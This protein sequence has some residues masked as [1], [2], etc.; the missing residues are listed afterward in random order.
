[1]ASYI[2]SFYEND[3]KERN[4]VLTTHSKPVEYKGYLIYHRI[5]GTT[6]N[7]DVFDSVKDG[8]CVGMSAGLNGAK[9]RI[10]KLI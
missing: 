4:P 1:M 10:D 9:N 3:K 6:K 2:N 5:S 8:V 7:G